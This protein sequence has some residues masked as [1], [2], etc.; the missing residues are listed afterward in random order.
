[1][2]IK[3]LAEIATELRLEPE[4]EIVIDSGA[5]YGAVVTGYRIT[6]NM[7]TEIGRAHV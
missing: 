6:T 4:T 2:K 7:R 3:E 1:M 5:E